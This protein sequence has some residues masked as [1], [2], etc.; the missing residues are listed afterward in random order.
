MEV[1][2]VMTNNNR[3]YVE[4]VEMAV[5]NRVNGCTWSDK[6]RSIYVR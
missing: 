5:L 3:S 6:I 2:L 4:E 1:K